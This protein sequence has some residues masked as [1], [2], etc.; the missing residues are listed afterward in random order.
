M[1]KKVAES[2]KENLQLTT[3]SCTLE[4]RYSK[5]SSVG[6]FD[7]WSGGNKENVVKGYK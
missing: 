7:S 4:S 6:S 3:C 5:Y 2:E 1:N